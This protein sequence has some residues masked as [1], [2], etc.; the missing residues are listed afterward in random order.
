MCQ[1]DGANDET[2][3][4]S[5]KLEISEEIK[6]RTK[7]NTNVAEGGC[8][9]CMEKWLRMVGAVGFGDVQIV[10]SVSFFHAVIFAV[11]CSVFVV[12]RL[13]RI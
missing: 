13:C 8:Q 1:D 2:G 3:E 6:I 9:T 4:P 12:C 7:C 10:K 5:S 11:S